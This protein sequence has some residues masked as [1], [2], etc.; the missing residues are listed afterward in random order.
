M[1]QMLCQD[2]ILIIAIEISSKN[3][4]HVTDYQDNVVKQD[5]LLLVLDYIKHPPQRSQCMSCFH[6]NNNMSA[7]TF[8]FMLHEV[9]V[10]LYENIQKHYKKLI[11]W[12]AIQ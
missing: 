7:L 12:Y 9:H 2:S 1:L 5:W 8:K 3:L 10:L 11:L 6:R 4:H